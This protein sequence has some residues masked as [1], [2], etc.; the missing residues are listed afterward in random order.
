MA[1][2]QRRLLDLDPFEVVSKFPIARSLALEFA[3]QDAQGSL[4]MRGRR[5]E[6]SYR[7]TAPNNAKRLATVTNP[8]QKV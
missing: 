1:L 5:G 7:F 2:V 4:R 6:L 3:Q 8:I